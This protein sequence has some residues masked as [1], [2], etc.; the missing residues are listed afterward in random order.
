MESNEEKSPQAIIKQQLDED[1]WDDIWVVLDKY[2]VP[3]SA[4]ALL[5]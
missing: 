3:K 2:I 4:M 1:F 5:L